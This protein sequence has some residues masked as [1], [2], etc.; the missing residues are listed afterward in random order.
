VA[1][2]VRGVFSQTDRPGG[3]GRQ[4]HCRRA[5]QLLL[6]DR[7][8]AACWACRSRPS[9]A[10]CALGWR[11]K[12]PPICTTSKYPAAATLQLP[13]KQQGDL[14]ALLQLTVRSRQRRA[15]ADS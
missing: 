7:R 2:A 11:A 10:R 13:P 8:K 1:K 6:V 4:Q 5:A 9:W 14:A 12:P 3:R 15:G